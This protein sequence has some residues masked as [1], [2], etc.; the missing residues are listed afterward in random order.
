[1]ADAAPRDPKRIGG[2]KLV[3]LIAAVLGVL[4][5]TYAGYIHSV[6]ERRWQAM[7]KSIQEV[8]ALYAARNAPRPVLRGTAVPGYAWDDYSPAL[9]TMK[10]APTS[11][12][13]EFV[14]RGP[15]ADRTKVE[16]AVAAHGSALDGLRKGV[17]KADG[18]FRIRWEQGFSA[19]IPGLLQ[20]QN[21]ANLAVCKSRLLAD[22]GKHRE[23][24]ELM[25]DTC[26][27][28][29][30]LG[31]NQTLI[32]EMI[33]IAITGIAL[34][35]LRDLI[36]RGK[37]SKED[38]QEIDREL[39]ILDASFPRNGHS[40]MNEAVALGYEFLKSDGNIDISSLIVGSGGPGWNYYLWKAVFPRRLICAD[41]YF[42]ELDYMKQ[43]A[44]A[45]EKSWGA[46]QAVGSI[47]DV[48]IR[49]L[50]NPIARLSMVSLTGSNRAG[51]EQRTHL[52]LVRGA[53]HY[54]TTGSLPVL[55]DPFGTKLLGSE[56][57]GKV[58]IWSVGWDRVDDG[59]KGEWKPRAGPDIVLEFD[60]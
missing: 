45:D 32:S 60:K 9:M 34:E 38:L 49:K 25:L 12:L 44:A 33:S 54:R 55:D 57:G 43:F 4:A 52:Q 30:D 24:A 42:T 37:L 6:A 14:G 31:Y 5:L 47:T 50:R 17:M 48:E 59:G 19:D 56:Q 22:E 13:G 2:W 26:Q 18:M 58:K 28:A 23:A 8:H 1:M 11:V 36:L 21:M 20:S 7:E 27:F 15:K 35:E 10:G 3:G 16:A 51:R 41:A 29:H 39:E 40:M 46:C 53:A